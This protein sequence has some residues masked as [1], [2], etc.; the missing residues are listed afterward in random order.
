[1]R[2]S[3]LHKITALFFGLIMTT[4]LPSSWAH[5]TTA[6]TAVTFTDQDAKRIARSYLDSI[7]FL[8]AGTSLHVTAAIDDAELKEGTWIVRVRTGKRLPT[9]KGVVL[10]NAQT[11]EVQKTWKASHT[12]TR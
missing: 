12:G 8:R 5:S 4:G 3:P 6:D 7:G 1:M 9:T 2:I 10:I 11:G